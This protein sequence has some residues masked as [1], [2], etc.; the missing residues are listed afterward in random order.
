M[1][2]KIHNIKDK[3]EILAQRQLDQIRESVQSAAPRLC[4]CTDRILLFLT[5]HS[6][7][8]TPVPIT[9]LHPYGNLGRS[10]S[11]TC[12]VH[13]GLVSPAGGD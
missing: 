3:T 5:F 13:W 7:P 1:T 8:G 10:I 12:G 2:I 11:F 4:S 6:L 9:L